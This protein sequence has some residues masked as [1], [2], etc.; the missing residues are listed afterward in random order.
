MKSALLSFLILIPFLMNGQ[1]KKS[2]SELT[3]TDDPAW[4]IVQDWVKNAEVKVDVLSKDDKK[5][6]TELVM[7]QITTRS[8]MGAIIYETGGIS[9]ENGMIRILGSGNTKLNRGLMTWNKNKSFKNDE[10]LKFLLVA[11]DAFGG[12]F[13]INGGGIS[14]ESIGRIFY[15]AP[16]TLQWENLDLTYSDFLTFCFSKKI[17]EFYSDFKWKNFNK[18]MNDFDNDKAFSFYPYLFTKEG[19]DIE[20]VS[21]KAVPIEELWFLYNDLQKQLAK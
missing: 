5:A 14:S 12:F 16:D 7:A 4:I 9:I 11:D 10:S 15:F 1:N 2:F 3:K 8:P 17:H 18:E 19:Q 6:E 20:A 21:K 13:A